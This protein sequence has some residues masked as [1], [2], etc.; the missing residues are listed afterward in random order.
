MAWLDAAIPACEIVENELKSE[1]NLYGVGWG[2]HSGQFMLTKIVTTEKV[3]VWRALS[4]TG[5]DAKAAALASDDAV[6]AGSLKVVRA[7][8]SGQYHVQVTT[9]TRTKTTTYVNQL[10]PW[11]VPHL[12]R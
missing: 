9:V 1:Q 11:D 12:A 6:K 2:E 10:E 4:K 7:D 8:E 5:A 3:S